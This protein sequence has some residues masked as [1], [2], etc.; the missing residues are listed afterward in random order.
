MG[1]ADLVS[2]SEALPA[3]EEALQRAFGYPVQRVSEPVAA[4]TEGFERFIG[5]QVSIESNYLARGFYGR[6]VSVTN[7]GD[8]ELLHIVSDDGEEY[9]VSSDMIDQF[10]PR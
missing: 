7:Q 8:K 10:S 4:D 1:K 9:L 3:I 2:M 6:L 5:K